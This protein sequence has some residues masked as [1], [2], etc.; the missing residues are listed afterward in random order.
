[1]EGV[2]AGDAALEEASTPQDLGR[3]GG[4]AL[5]GPAPPLRVSPV[6]GD[7]EPD[8]VDGSG[9]RLAAV[10]REEGVIVLDGRVRGG[11]DRRSVADRWPAPVTWAARSWDARAGAPVTASPGSP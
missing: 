10:L 8:L 4:P 6:Q 3:P 2:L 9:D 7:D 5:S 11:H 1:M